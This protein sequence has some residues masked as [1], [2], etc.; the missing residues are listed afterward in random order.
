M[1]VE[2]A[3]RTLQNRE[4]L[5]ALGGSKVT[6][7]M[8]NLTTP[9]TARP[10]LHSGQATPTHPVG[11]WVTDRNNEYHCLGSGDGTIEQQV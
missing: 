10:A 5:V 1:C 8:A 2:M 7:R 9:Y 4:I 6:Q 11:L 3:K